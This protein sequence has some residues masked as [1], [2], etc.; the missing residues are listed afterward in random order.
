M[1]NILRHTKVA[2]QAFKED[3]GVYKLD[4]T[5]QI[6]RMK[7]PD[8]HMNFLRDY[9]E[10]V[11]N[12]NTISEVSK[13]YIRSIETNPMDAIRTWNNFQNEEYAKIPDKKA[14]NHIYYD[15]KRLLELFPDDMIINVINKKADLD[16][17]ETLLK[18][19]ISKKAG[20]SL[21]NKMS[22]LRIPVTVNSERPTD[23][24]I[25]YFFMLF[26]PYVNRVVKQVEDELPR[27]VI[28][29]I[30][31]LS[32]KSKMTA[33]EKEVIDRLESLNKPIDYM[34]E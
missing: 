29:Y 9:I 30:N 31:Y 18:V 5:S 13:I 20:K 11:M 1:A 32:Q 4:T 27:D 23:E 6:G 25:D 7:L 3:H 33:E 21:L 16:T 8:R 10:F 2:Y 28:G 26:S 34:T 15:T 14:S 24:E 22:T 19:A 12:S 17:Y